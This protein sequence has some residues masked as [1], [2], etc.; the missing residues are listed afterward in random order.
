MKRTVA[1]LLLLLMLLCAAS[2]LAAEA[3]TPPNLPELT[4]TYGL[5][6][7]YGDLEREW[8]H[9]KQW[10]LE[11]KAWLSGE[12]DALLAK[13]NARRESM[14]ADLTTRFSYPLGIYQHSLPDEAVIDQ[15]TAFAMAC[16]QFIT[17]GAALSPDGMTDI[18]FYYLVDDPQQPVWYHTVSIG[19]TSY[20]TYMDARTG[21]FAN[22]S[23]FDVI[24][25]ASAQLPADIPLHLYEAVALYRPADAQW[26]VQ[27]HHVVPAHPSYVVLLSDATLEV[28]SVQ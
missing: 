28:L 27:F 5:S 9:V 8:G 12:L 3:F 20:R 15:A 19:G 24:D 16:D 25:K 21:K 23:A 2:A 13:E 10:T 7:F 26:E 17:Q 22:A 1:L 18:G 4:S 6:Q 11:Q 14:G